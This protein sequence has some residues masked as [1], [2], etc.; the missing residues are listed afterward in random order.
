MGGSRG[1]GGGVGGGG[2]E[3]EHGG[4][5]KEEPVCSRVRIRCSPCV[6]SSPTLLPVAE[7]KPMGSSWG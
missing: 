1:V 7:V 5:L 4:R 2:Y 3:Q 6:C